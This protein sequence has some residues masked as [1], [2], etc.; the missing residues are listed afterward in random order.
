VSAATEG[1][2]AEGERVLGNGFGLG[3]VKARGS[4]EAAGN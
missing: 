2:E 3:E 1:P 4:A